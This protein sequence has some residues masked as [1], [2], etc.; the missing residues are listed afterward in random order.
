MP[1][2]E[3]RHLFRHGLRNVDAAV[4]VCPDHWT[5]LS[6]V[7]VL[8]ED[9]P[10]QESFLA[11]AL[12]L[13]R[14]FQARPI[15]LTVAR[16]ERRASLRQHFLQEVLA[17]SGTECEFDMMVGGEVRLAVARIA[18]WRRCPLVMMERQTAP[19]WWR[20]WQGGTAED[21][22]GL[23][24]GFAFLALPGINV[25]VNAPAA[26]GKRLAAKEPFPIAVIR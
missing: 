4:L 3:K 24:N 9:R 12:D 26:G 20:W 6:R 19:P 18:R 5:E 21:L 7:L 1:T 14:H 10:H 8:H 22:L 23:P 17:D 25:L 16:S 11:S 13:C 2:A 15:I